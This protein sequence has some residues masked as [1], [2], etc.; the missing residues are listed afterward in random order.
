MLGQQVL[1]FGWDEAQGSD[2]GISSG[3]KAGCGFLIL[4]QQVGLVADAQS[5][6]KLAYE[7]QSH[8]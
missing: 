3:V 6:E 7:Q 4:E 1:G 2:G 5:N 8:Y